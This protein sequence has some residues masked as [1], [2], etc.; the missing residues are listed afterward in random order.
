MKKYI[1][2]FMLGI[3]WSCGGGNRTEV[4][5]TE[6]P[7]EK[8]EPVFRLEKFK[9]KF[10]QGHVRQL[11]LEELEKYGDVHF[12]DLFDTLTAA[13]RFQVFQDSFYLENQISEY[14]FFSIQRSMDPVTILMT[15]KDELCG[16]NE[17]FVV[18][19]VKGKLIDQATIFQSGGLGCKFIYQMTS[20]FLNDSLIEC[21]AEKTYNDFSGEMQFSVEDTDTKLLIKHNGVIETL[22]SETDY[23]P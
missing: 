16:G 20:T 11:G 3:T 1:C 14:T 8:L 22:F 4:L 2:I 5:N 12:P 10:K 21:H 15:R 18:T 17:I 23:A 7:Q 13:E 19:Y 6:N 9:S